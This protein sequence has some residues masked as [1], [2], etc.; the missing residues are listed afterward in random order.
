MAHADYGSVERKLESKYNLQKPQ[1]VTNL[2]EDIHK[3][4]EQRYRGTDT[5]LLS[6]LLVDLERLL[7]TAELTDRQLQAIW[8]KYEQDLPQGEVAE[9]MGI[10]Q[11]AVSKH[12]NR[13]I[14]RM[15]IVAKEEE[16][17]H[18]KNH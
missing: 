6:S 11:Q 4:R 18:G 10:S 13:A 5:T 1:G 7:T 8:H 9:I 2:M 15:V 16:A 12:L 17:N 14:A 3:L